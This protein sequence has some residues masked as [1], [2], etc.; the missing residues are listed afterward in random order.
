ETDAWFCPEPIY[1]R[2]WKVATLRYISDNQLVTL[3]FSPGPSAD[4]EFILVGNSGKIIGRIAALKLE[5]TEDFQVFS[6]G[7]TN[8]MFDK[9]RSF[10]IQADTLSEIKQAFYEVGIQGKLKRNLQVYCDD[11]FSVL[12]QFLTAGSEIEILLAKA[13]GE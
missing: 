5:I 10:T 9:K 8:T 6:S 3:Y 7:H 12:Q 11:S 1:S 2:N 4:P 13:S